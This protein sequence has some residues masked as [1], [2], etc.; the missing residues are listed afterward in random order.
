LA[1]FDWS[2]ISDSIE[3]S[4]LF[5]AGDDGGAFTVKVTVDGNEA[6]AELRVPTKDETLPSPQGERYVRWHGLVPPQK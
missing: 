4:G 5:T 6:H 1:R 2:A 3:L